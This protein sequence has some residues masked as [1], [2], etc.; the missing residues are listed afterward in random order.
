MCSMDSWMVGWMD[1]GLIS[2]FRSLAEDK[3]GFLYT[4]LKTTAGARKYS[5]NPSIFPKQRTRVWLSKEQGSGEP[6][7]RTAVNRRLL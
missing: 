6:L 2:V 3:L 5:G 7:R 4:F 1:D